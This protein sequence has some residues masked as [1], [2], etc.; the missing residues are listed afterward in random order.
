MEATV[1]L[2]YIT[3]GSLKTSRRDF[4]PEFSQI[5]LSLEV[6][7]E[8]WQPRTGRDKWNPSSRTFVEVSTVITKM[9]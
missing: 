1:N 7:D 5:R 6:P 3:S 4:D 2:E 8:A 9:Y